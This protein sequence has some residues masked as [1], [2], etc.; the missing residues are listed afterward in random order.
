[1]VLRCIALSAGL[2]LTLSVKAAPNCDS[3]TTTVDMIDCGDIDFKNADAELNKVYG[4]LMKVLD[5]EGQTKLKTAQ[6]AWLTFR[7][8]NADFNADYARGG[9]LAPILAISTRTE[10]T[11]LRADELKKVLGMLQS[12]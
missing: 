5:K 4:Q 9:T 10:M 11:G 1:M 3:P 12:Q 2:V 6:R 8:A 7:D